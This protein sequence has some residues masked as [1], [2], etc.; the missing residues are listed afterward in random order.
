MQIHAR[1]REASEVVVLGSGLTGLAAASQLGDRAIVLEKNDSPGGLVR[2]LRLG[3]WHF[4]LVVHQ[5][6]IPDPP[7]LRV[8]R[9]LMGKTLQPSYPEAFVE[10]L[11]GTTRYPFQMHLGDL[12]AAA[13]RRCFL[14]FSR[15]NGTVGHQAPEN[16]SQWLAHTFGHRCVRLS[17]I[18]I[19][20]K[21]GNDRYRS[22]PRP[23]S[24]GRSRRRTRRRCAAA[25]RHRIIHSK[26]ITLGAGIPAPV[27]RR[28]SGV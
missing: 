5:L 13:M 17:S 19:I 16:F 28:P 6:Y 26:R 8:V 18:P 12:P 23:A 20:A 27:P 11:D 3:G 1:R 21:C 10:T 25:R 9:A 4:D 22:W 2:T 14:D 24:S 7:T 15:I